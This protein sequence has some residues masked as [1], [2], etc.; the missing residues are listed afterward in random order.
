MYGFQHR[1]CLSLLLFLWLSECL[2]GIPL[3][4]LLFLDFLNEFS[5]GRTFYFMI[6]CPQEPLSLFIFLRVSYF[7]IYFRWSEFF[8]LCSCFPW[9]WQRGHLRWR[10]WAQLR[11]GSPLLG[12]ISPDQELRQIPAR[13][14]AREVPIFSFSLSLLRNTA[15]PG[16]LLKARVPCEVASCSSLWSSRTFCFL[17]GSWHFEWSFSFFELLGFSLRFSFS[18]SL[19]CVS[20]ST[21]P[22]PLQ[23]VRVR[24]WEVSL[25][26]ASAYIS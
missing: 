19:F 23:R 22:C 5:S 16:D 26:E 9:S 3:L 21:L 25:R 17:P 10:A 8:L 7:L 13:H 15:F 4:M 1:R 12:G 6:S 20:P 2:P 11:A 14:T 18:S 24:T